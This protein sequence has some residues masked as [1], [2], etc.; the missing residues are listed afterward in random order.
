MR[1]GDG[2]EEDAHQQGEGGGD[3]GKHIGM[4]C[5]HGRSLIVGLDGS[6]LQYVSFAEVGAPQVVYKEI[7]NNSTLSYLKPISTSYSLLCGGIYPR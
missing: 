3:V 5:G 4:R 7:I 6:F 2:W 1:T